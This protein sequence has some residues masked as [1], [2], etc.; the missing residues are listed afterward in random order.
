MAIALT[1]LFWALVAAVTFTYLARAVVVGRRWVEPEAGGAG[2]AATTLGSGCRELVLAGLTLL[3]WP[4]GLVPNRLFSQ[5]GRGDPILLVPGALMTWSAC[6]PLRWYLKARL[7]NPVAQVSC[8][9]L[10]G[11]PVRMAAR[12]GDRIRTLARVSEGGRVHVIA[13]GEGGLA[14]LIAQ[15]DDPALP[16]GQVVT[17]AAPAAAPAAGSRVGRVFLPGGASR[18][19][20]IGDSL[21]SPT[22]AIRSEGD[23]LV[24]PDESWPD[25]APEDVLTLA[26]HG[27]LSTWYSPRTWQAALDALGLPGQPGEPDA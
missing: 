17:V 20:G 24:L 10:F 16:V 7:P 4:V 26:T 3:A 14:T 19:D 12:L 15:R 25:A 2:P 23:N 9:P 21:P 5:P 8:A 22:L 1:A 6:L 13:L 11:S 18:Y 27:H